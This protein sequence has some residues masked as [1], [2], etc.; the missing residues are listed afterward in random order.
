MQEFR[1]VKA[2][3]MA[4]QITLD[5]YALTEAFPKASLLASCCRCA[6]LP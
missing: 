4:H 1:T 2:W 6:A 5:V 3:Q